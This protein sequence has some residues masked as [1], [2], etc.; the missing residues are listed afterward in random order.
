MKGNRFSVFF[1]KLKKDMLDMTAREKA[2]H[3]WYHFKWYIIAMLVCM[4]ATISLISTMAINHRNTVFGGGLINVSVSDTGTAFLTEDYLQA[5][6]S[7]NKKYQATLY[8][9]GIIGMDDAGLTQ[10]ASFTISFMTMLGAK[11]FDYLILDEAALNHYK[12]QGLFM[13]LRT[14]FSDAELQNMEQLLVYSDTYDEDGN[15]LGQL[16]PVG[17]CIEDLPF[18]ENCLNST[19]DVYLVFAGNAPHTDRLV[20]FYNYL[21]SWNPAS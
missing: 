19:S 13:N 10:N 7:N 20:A 16:Y 12:E 18:T 17:I 3:I 11:E 5:T 8:A 14:L 1:Q 2:E 21:C 6:N 9:P 15:A 4:I